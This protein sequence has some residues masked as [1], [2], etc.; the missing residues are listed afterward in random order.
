MFPPI[1]KKIIRA[2]PGPDELFY[3]FD[4]SC[5]RYR[6]Q[7]LHNLLMILSSQRGS[8]IQDRYHTGICFCSDSPSK[9]LTKFHLHLRHN[10]RVDVILQGHI[11]CLLCFPDGIR[12]WE[13]QARDDEGRNYIAW[14]VDS[15]PAAS[16][17]KQ[18]GILLSFEATDRILSLIHI[19][20]REV[21]VVLHRTAN[22]QYYCTKCSFAG[23]K[24]DIREMYREL[25]KKY[26]FAQVRLTLKDIEQL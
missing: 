3:V 6:R 22:D 14:E 10:N 15:L 26:R 5:N 12:H 19:F 21:D 24:T 7:R 20:S 23:S 4:L 2:F 17:C 18:Y 25:Q 9:S 16:R 8:V 11:V 1:Y 13:R